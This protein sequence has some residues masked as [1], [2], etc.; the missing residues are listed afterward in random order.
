MRY[1]GAV[2]LIGYG[3]RNLHSALRSSR[4]LLAAGARASGLGRTLAACLA[5]TWL[6]PHVY[7]DTV[8]LL[9]A[10]STRFPG[11]GPS[12]A[13]PKNRCSPSSSRRRR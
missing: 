11:E 2:F 8:M 4:A 13:S 12:F 1:G 7:L 5:V 10:I 6:N 3:A 9:G